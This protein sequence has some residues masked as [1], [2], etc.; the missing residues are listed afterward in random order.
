[1]ISKK[2]S[3]SPK[4]STPNPA[5]TP[6]ANVTAASGPRSTRMAGPKAAR[7]IPGVETAE[8]RAT[9][10]TPAAQGGAPKGTTPKR[11]TPK[12]ATPKSAAAKSAPAKDIA[13]NPAARPQSSAAVHPSASQPTTVTSLGPAGENGAG[14]PRAISDEDIRVRAYFLSVEHRGQGSPEY[15][16]LLA[17]RELRPSGNAQ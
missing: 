14:A 8:G 16:W 4:S 2:S 5:P 11:A 10:S 15:F 17:E 3:R 9:A 7:P 1:M 13:K 6:E 12:S